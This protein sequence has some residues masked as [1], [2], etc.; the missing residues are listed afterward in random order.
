MQ[1]LIDDI[2]TFL[3]ER[4]INCSTAIVGGYKVIKA[5]R[6]ISGDEKTILP[7]EIIARDIKQAAIQAEEVTG[8]I[9]SIDI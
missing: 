2:L 7:V 8:F 5:V 3:G 9:Q 4:G 1:K 6:R